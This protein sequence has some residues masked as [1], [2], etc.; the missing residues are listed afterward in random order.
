MMIFCNCEK[1]NNCLY[2]IQSLWNCKKWHL[3]KTR[4]PGIKSST[5]AK[6]FLSITPEL[7]KSGH[8]LCVYILV[9]LCLAMMLGSE[10]QSLKSRSCRFCYAT[11]LS[12][13]QR[14]HIPFSDLMH[15]PRTFWKAFV[16]THKE[17]KA[18][19]KS[20]PSKTTFLTCKTTNYLFFQQ[21]SLWFF[22]L[23]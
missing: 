5:F 6:C 20:K 22:R 11:F 19:R 1:L 2:K 14:C 23:H 8:S 12:R 18:S 9:S 3:P 13:S 7:R 16:M 10:W 17:L 21:A 4:V 15:F